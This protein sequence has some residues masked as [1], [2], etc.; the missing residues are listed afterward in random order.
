MSSVP[1]H[2][3]TTAVITVRSLTVVGVVNGSDMDI[4]VAVAHRAVVL[5]DE[6]NSVPMVVFS[7]AS[8]VTVGISVLFV[9][10]KNHL[11]IWGHS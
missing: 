9:P 7:V 4:R 11:I 2:V 10:S 6:V 5:G 1:E 8:R 3:V